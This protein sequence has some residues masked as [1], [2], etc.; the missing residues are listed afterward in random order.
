MNTAEKLF[1]IHE[2]N[3]LPERPL[4]YFEELLDGYYLAESDIEG[5]FTDLLDDLVQGRSGSKLFSGEMS[6]PLSILEELRI[7]ADWQSDFWGEGLELVLPG[8]NLVLFIINMLSSD[9]EGHSCSSYEVR[10]ENR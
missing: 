1:T 5:W 6:N 7:D 3:F 9:E 8:Q 2:R 10:H 4:A